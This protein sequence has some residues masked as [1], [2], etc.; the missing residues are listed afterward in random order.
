MIL[1]LGRGKQYFVD[2]GSSLKSPYI[3][4]CLCSNSCEEKEEELVLSSSSLWR[5]S[6]KENRTQEGTLEICCGI[7]LAY[8]EEGG[9]I[10]IEG[11]DQD[12]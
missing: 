1:V 12:C 4:Y 10:N 7:F 9:G 3:V 6:L 11:G 8:N 2:K 5:E